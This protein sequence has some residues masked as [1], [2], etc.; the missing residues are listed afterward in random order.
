MRKSIRIFRAAEQA[1]GRLTG[2]GTD[3][4]CWMIGDSLSHDIIGARRAGWNTVWFNRGASDDE[5]REF[6]DHIVRSETEMYEAIWLT[7][8]K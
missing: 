6:S 4:T 5:G 3:R 1:V 7:F 8:G 2:G